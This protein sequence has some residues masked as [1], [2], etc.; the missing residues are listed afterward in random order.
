MRIWNP[1]AREKG[2]SLT[3]SVDE[4]VPL[5]LM[6]DPIRIRQCVANLLSNAI[7]FT[8]EGEVGLRVS[9]RRVPEDGKWR[10]A[11]CVSDTGIGMDEEAVSRLFQPFSQGDVSIGQ[12]YGGTGLGLA[13]TRQLAELMGGDV[14]VTSTPGKGSLFTLTFLAEEAV[15]QDGSADGEGHMADPVGEGGWRDGLR[16]LIA[17]DHPLNRKLVRM[18]LEPYGAVVSEVSDGDEVVDALRK[19]SFDILLLDAHMRRMD[20]IDAVRQLRSAGE[21]WS[22]IPVLILTADAMAG[23]RD[24]YILAGADGYVAKPIDQRELCAEMSRVLL[25]SKIQVAS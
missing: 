3:S 21:A 16:V 11:I 22:G 1:R 18:F 9:A 5:R 17:D 4:D 13:I 7:K 23:D 2:I 25:P 15:P 6:F 14:T 24:R 12:Q 8:S 19:D 20:G 10:V